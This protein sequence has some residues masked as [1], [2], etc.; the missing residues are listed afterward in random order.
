MIAKTLFKLARRPFMG[1]IVGF[2]LSYMHRLTPI[3]RVKNTAN[4]LAF[5]HPR[6]SW[7]THML[8][9]PKR[10]IRTLLDLTND[11]NRRYFGDVLLAARDLVKEHRLDG[12]EFVLCANGG[13]YQDVYQVHFHLLTGERFVRPLPPSFAGETIYQDH[14]MQ[15]VA[16]PNPTR[17]FHVV[18]QPNTSVP[19]LTAFDSSYRPAVEAI[20]DAL[21]HLVHKCDLL[22]RGYSLVIQ[23]SPDD[24]ATGLLFHVISGKRL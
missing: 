12:E 13:P 19:P 9:I 21:S 3:K 11:Q 15:I 17:E 1:T 14:T 4:I 20:G 8:V 18:I 10:P 5:H 23:E 2:G 16:H 6:P 24:Q 22:T 7:N